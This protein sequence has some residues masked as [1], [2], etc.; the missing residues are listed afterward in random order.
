MKKWTKNFYLYDKNFNFIDTF[1]SLADLK[2]SLPK[3]QWFITFKLLKNRNAKLQVAFS[4]QYPILKNPKEALQFIKNKKSLQQLS[5]PVLEILIKLTRDAYYN[6]GNALITDSKYDAL[7][8]QLKKLHPKSLVLKTPGFKPK[9]KKIKLPYYMG[10]MDKLD[11]VDSW[12]YPGP[13]VVMEKLDGVSILYMNDK[14]I[15]KLYTRGNGTI[16]EDKTHYLKVLNLPPLKKNTAIRGE[17]LISKAAFKKLEDKASNPRNY[18]SG[19]INRKDPVK[20][21]AKLLAFEILNPR[22]KVSKQLKALKQKKFDI[23]WYT[24][25]D[26]I[27]SQS[28]LEIL[29][30]RKQKSKYE[31]DGLVVYANDKKYPVNTSGNPKW[32]FAYKSN[33]V[34]T[35]VKVTIKKI[36]WQPSKDGRL[37]PVVKFDP[38]TFDGSTVKQ[39]TGNNIDYMKKNGIGIG[40]EVVIVKSGGIIPKIIEVI[41]PSTNLSLPKEFKE[42]G[43]K[44][45]YTTTRTNETQAQYLLYQLTCLAL[46]LLVKNLLNFLLKQ[47]LLLSEN[48]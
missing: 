31:I 8:E 33:E 20:S 5:V 29:K 12:S 6:T 21:K 9:G 22:T 4:R 10:S 48:F 7:E 40:A 1:Q 24:V 3:K 47:K 11:N 23:P 36:K 43:D 18:I 34:F 44:H 27:S 39:A 35:K 38:I 26:N 15:N 45:I 13:Y 2:G 32:A 17:I 30:E 14:G 16:G 19:V 25:V 41:K 37:T 28:L 42:T 46:N